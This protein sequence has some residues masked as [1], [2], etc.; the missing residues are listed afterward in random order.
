MFERR[1]RV[2]GFTSSCLENDIGVGLTIGLLLRLDVNRK[3]F[4]H[5]KAR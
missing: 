2:F 5:G 3:S 4:A 1:G